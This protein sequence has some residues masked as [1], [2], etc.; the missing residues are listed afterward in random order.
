MTFATTFRPSLALMLFAWTVGVH[1][2]ELPG[3]VRD[4]L[5]AAAIPETNVAIWVQPVDGDAPPLAANPDRPMNPASVMKLVTAFAALERFGP[6]H[7]WT[8]RVTTNATV[9]GGVLDG[10]LFVVGGG[11]PM[12]TDERMWKLLR[13][14]Q[15][16]GIETVRGDIVLDG[17]ALRLPPHDPQ[18][19]DGRGLRPYN[20]AAHGLLVHFNTL[21]LALLPA[22]SAGE[23]VTVAANPPLQGLEIDNRI[24]TADGDC[25]VWYANLDARLET[26]AAGER[27]VLLGSL[28]ARCGRRDW[29]VSP[30]A[31]ERFAVAAVAGLWAETG[32]KVE[33]I[34]R[35]GFAPADA[36]PLLEETSPPL[37]DALREMNKWS[38]NVI[39]R[40]LLAS[41]GAGPEASTPA[42]GAGGAPADAPAGGD[43]KPGEAV[44][45]DEPASVAAASDP[46]APIETYG[47]R[48]DTA[49][50]EA[51]AI[52]MVAA[53]ADA[54]HAQLAAAG[55]DTTG[56]VIAN[57]SG[58]SR[59]E[60]VTARTLGELL[61]AA[62]RRPYMPEF[63][64]S[65]PVAGV[66]GT[67][68]GRLEGSPASGHAHVKTGYING[69]RAIAG[70]VLDRHGRRHVVAMLV[71]DPRAVDSR[72]ALDALIEWVWQGAR[73]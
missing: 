11:D 46:A 68:R 47:I 4:A 24:A 54:A 55:I 72:P 3:T 65:L 50:V 16:L 36:K 33:G 58:L 18:A 25:G 69:V 41:L 60:S 62:W 53:G 28:P 13:R 22:A 66:D 5:D 23:P 39:A 2:A 45:P 51:H 34:V 8:T 15:A 32:G 21:Q 30:F 12:L 57:G 61:L 48:S 70:Y 43:A 64:A 27:V 67:A 10:D 9:H 44:V 35:P 37:G 40:Q 20:S 26:G 29:S 19:F 63:V 31:P 71:N 17:S 1:A 14:I 49:S 6:A 73:P 7:A 59:I 42:D 38:S 56:L 52:D